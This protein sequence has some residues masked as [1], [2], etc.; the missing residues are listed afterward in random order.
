MGAIGY[1]CAMSPPDPCASKAVGGVAVLARKPRALFSPQP[2]T[3]MFHEYFQQG[4]LTMA[5]VPVG[6]T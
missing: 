4:R 6:E 5:F 3:N 2:R 1:N